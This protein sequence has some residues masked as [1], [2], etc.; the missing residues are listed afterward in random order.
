MEASV[1]I[2]AAVSKSW[3]HSWV[4]GF[5]FTFSA[6]LGRYSRTSPYVRRLIAPFLPDITP[7][8]HHACV[9]LM[10]RF[11]AECVPRGL[12]DTRTVLYE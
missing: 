12:L 6:G 1:V 8:L 2:S 4:S 9:V 11:K 10:P 5:R 7:I 3:N